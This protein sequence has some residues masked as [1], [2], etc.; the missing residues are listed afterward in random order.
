MEG[1]AGSGWPGRR[2]KRERKKAQLKGI[3]GTWSSL[4]WSSTGVRRSTDLDLGPGMGGG[5]YR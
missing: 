3:E 5:K 1:E 2:M 4:V